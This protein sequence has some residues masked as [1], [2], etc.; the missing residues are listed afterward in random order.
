M[1]TCPPYLALPSKGRGVNAYHRARTPGGSCFFTVVTFRRQPLLAH[2]ES[3]R[4]LREIVRETRGKYPFVIDAWVLLP[5]HMHCIWTL[6]PGDADYSTR[7]GIIKSGF[8]NQA[9]EL[10]R[11]PEWISPSKSKHRESTIWQRRF[12]EHHSA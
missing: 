10:F 1:S 2:P 6:P 12:W 8:S 9:R 3:R 11:R 4:I 7:W 5:E